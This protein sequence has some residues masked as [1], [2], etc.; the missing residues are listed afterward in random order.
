MR[1]VLVLEKNP[2]FLQTWQYLLAQRGVPFLVTEDES[3]ALSFCRAHHPDAILAG[4]EILAR[5]GQSLSLIQE[6]RKA[7]PHTVLVAL[8]NARSIP[9]APL[10]SC[11]GADYHVSSTAD[12]AVVLRLLDGAQARKYRRKQTLTMAV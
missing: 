11:L 1:A 8:W 5:G 12:M 6:F 3:Q 7:A 4:G 9:K 10:R 2:D